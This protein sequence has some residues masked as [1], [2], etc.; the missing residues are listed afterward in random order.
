MPL[1]AG[2]P[3][4]HELVEYGSQ[5]LQFVEVC[6]REL[7]QP[8]LTMGSETDPRQAAVLGVTAAFH[9]PGRRRPV[10]EFHRTVVTQQQVTSQIADCRILAAAVTLDGDQ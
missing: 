7:A 4:G 2:S 3:A 8:R 9:E 1:A 10:H 6:G 5:I